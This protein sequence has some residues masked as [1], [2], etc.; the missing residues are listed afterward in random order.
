MITLIIGMTLLAACAA[1]GYISS[2]PDGR[3]A[4]KGPTTTRK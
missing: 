2:T 3:A 1:S 4:C